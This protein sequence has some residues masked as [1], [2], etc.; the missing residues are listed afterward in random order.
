MRNRPHSPSIHILDNVSLLHV[1]FLCRPLLLD[2]DEIEYVLLPGGKW[3][4]E[5]WWYKLTQICRRWRYLVLAST[6]YLG[7]C[8]IC[9][10]GTPELGNVGVSVNKKR[11]TPRGQRIHGCKCRDGRDGRDEMR[12]REREAK[13][14]ETQLGLRVNP[15]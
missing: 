11:K 13:S 7:I 1:F 5:R 9:T 14:G 4:R 15:P 3:V 8:L 12:A 2:E 10:Y 6:F